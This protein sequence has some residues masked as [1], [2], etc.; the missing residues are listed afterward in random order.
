MSRTIR[1]RTRLI[2]ASAAMAA[3]MF[4]LLPAAPAAA[5]DDL[6]VIVHGEAILGNGTLAC[7][8]GTFSGRAVGGFHGTPPNVEPVAQLVDTSASADY[9]YCNEAAT[10]TASGNITVAGHACTFSWARTGTIATV[11][12]GGD[13]EGEATAHLTVTS[14][15]GQIP[16][17][18][19]VTAQGSITHS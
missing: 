14:A 4:A 6:T 17:T 5:D 2:M 19:E 11:T 13:C 7:G 15:P 1:T 16:G 10:G 3:M 8:E 9:E 18:A 12:F